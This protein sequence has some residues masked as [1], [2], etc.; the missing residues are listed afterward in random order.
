MDKEQKITQIWERYQNSSSYLDVLGLTDKIPKCVKYYEGNQWPAATERTK[1]LPRPVINITKYVARNKKAGVLS[2]PVK[3]MFNAE[4][5]TDTKIINVW[6]EYIE[7]ELR[8]KDIDSRAVEEG[9][10]KGT[11]VYHYYWNPDKE[12]Y[13]ATAQGGA[14]VELLEPLNVRVANPLDYDEQKQ[15]WIIIVSREELDAIKDIAKAE[16]IDPDLVTT[17]QSDSSYME[18][19]QKGTDYVTVL[20]QYTKVD[21]QVYFEKSTKEVIFQKKRPLTPDVQGAMAKLSE[22]EEHESKEEDEAETGLAGTKSDIENKNEYK[23]NLY[24]IVIGNWEYRDKSIYGIGE[25]ETLI[26]NQDII[27]RNIAYQI[28]ARRDMSLG[29][30]MKKKGALQ[31]GETIS[32]APNQ[33]ITDHTQG[34]DWGIKPIPVNN[35]PQDGMQYVDALMTLIRT[36]TGATEVM[37][38]E[39]IGSNMS[40]AAISA[41][42]SQARMP[43]EELRQRFWRVKE[44][45]AL[46]LMLFYRIF[47]TKRSFTVYEYGDD[48]KKHNVKYQF[49]P[50]QIQNKKFDVVAT[51]GAGTTYSEITRLQLLEN[52]ASSGQITLEEL[53]DMAGDELLGDKE[54]L[55]EKIRLRKQSQ[56]VMLTQENEQ[57]KLQLQQAAEVMS[58]QNKA[59]AQAS[60]LVNTNRNLNM[61]IL[62]LETLVQK[63]MGRIQETM[64]DAQLFAQELAKRGAKQDGSSDSGQT[65]QQQNIK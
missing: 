23:F 25:V 12:G 50:S 45:Q 32:N 28:K 42:Q 38:G 55:L 48:G 53:I 37:S 54:E 14:E 39:V 4:D 61:T 21:G 29:G 40:G 8:M 2:T 36:T 65:I 26:E 16:G 56:I 44:K 24:P 60:Q 35:I 10:K 19:E 31:E 11:Y 17:D 64:G 9:A 58:E 34:N 62:E 6:H 57:M 59:V 33:I 18:E 20:T 1:S 41:L 3:I 51:A 52:L 43:L 15:K 13:D 7:K 46:I 30:W 47:Y 27:N 5:G 49:D 22:G 63:T